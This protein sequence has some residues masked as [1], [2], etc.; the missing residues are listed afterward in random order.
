MKYLSG[1]NKGFTM[2]EVLV[3]LAIIGILT[4]ILVVN[5]T[6]ARKNSRDKLRKSDL[7]SLQ[8][9]LEVYKAQ[10]GRYPASG[11]GADVN[12]WV[13]PGPLSS[14]GFS[15]NEYISGLAPNYIPALP[16]DPNQ[17]GELDR[18]YKYRTDAN[19]TMY[20]VVIHN[21]VESLTVQSQSD[22]FSRFPER[23]GISPSNLATN[24]YAI[25]ST[26]YECL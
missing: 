14:W 5:Y 2:I 25:Y 19:G 21:S 6:E 17:E 22:E 23:C 1:R 11:C 24:Q 26:G 12:L 4:A 10:N 18:G 9:A 16:V 7:K 20:K 15:C 3:V 13:G 8:L